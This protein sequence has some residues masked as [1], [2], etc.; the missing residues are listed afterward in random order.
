M[1]DFDSSPQQPLA[2]RDPRAWTKNALRVKDHAQEPARKQGR[3]FQ[4]LPSRTRMEDLAR[5]MAE[6]ERI[7]QGL[8]CIFSVVEPCRTLHSGSKRVAPSFSPLAGNVCCRSD[9]RILSAMR[10]SGATGM[11]RK[12]FI[13]HTRRPGYAS[14]ASQ[15]NRGRSLRRIGPKPSPCRRHDASGRKR[16]CVRARR[17]ANDRGQSEDGYNTLSGVAMSAN[18]IGQLQFGCRKPRGGSFHTT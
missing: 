5:Q 6:R 10:F 15:G 1:P 18:R 8:V 4:Y 13:I 3:P 7:Q 17:S 16:P 2:G 9:P 14:A 11:A 12:G